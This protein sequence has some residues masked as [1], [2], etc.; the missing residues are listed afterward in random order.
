MSKVVPLHTVPPVIV[1]SLVPRSVL[2]EWDE[3]GALCLEEHEHDHGDQGAH[4]QDGED[5]G[6]PKDWYHCV[7]QDDSKQRGDGEPTEEE[8]IYFDSQSI[9][10]KAGKRV[11]R[12]KR[13]WGGTY[14]VP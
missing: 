4:P 9:Q 10:K 1:L 12:V 5:G 8:G 13:E 3:H 14:S 11:R 6:P 2:V 7:V